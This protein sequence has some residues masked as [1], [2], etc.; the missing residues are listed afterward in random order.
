M[1][2]NKVTDGFNMVTVSSCNF[3]L[4]GIDRDISSVGWLDHDIRGM[5][6]VRTKEVFSL[7]A[8]V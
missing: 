2:S 6:P 5:Q 3:F 8:S 4:K 7:V 1:A